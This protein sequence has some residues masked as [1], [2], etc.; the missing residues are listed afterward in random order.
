MSFEEFALD[1]F[2]HGSNLLFLELLRGDARVKV[3]K[4]LAVMRM[5]QKG[6]ILIVRWGGKGAATKTERG[7]EHRDEQ[8]SAC[9]MKTNDAILSML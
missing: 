2:S 7:V 8:M 3:M 9:C 4:Q 1:N 6:K 5:K